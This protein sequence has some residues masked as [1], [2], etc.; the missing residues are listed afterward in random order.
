MFPHWLYALRRISRDFEELFYS[1]HQ[2]C[3]ARKWST[4]FLTLTSRSGNQISYYLH[5][6]YIG[7]GANPWKAVGK[8]SHTSGW[9]FHRCESEKNHFSLLIQEKISHSS[10][11]PWKEKNLCYLE[12][13]WKALWVLLT[14]GNVNTSHQGSDKLQLFDLKISSRSWPSFSLEI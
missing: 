10:F 6:C 5:N 7:P 1:F 9:T 2:F 11:L 14:S 12:T 4:E 13:G 3:L 8:T